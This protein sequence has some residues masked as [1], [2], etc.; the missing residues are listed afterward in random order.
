MDIIRKTGVLVYRNIKS[1]FK[2]KCAALSALPTLE[3]HLDASGWPRQY[4]RHTTVVASAAA[5]SKQQPSH[6][7][8]QKPASGLPMTHCAPAKQPGDTS[9][10]HTHTQNPIPV[11]DQL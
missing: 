5:G 3:Q 2:K 10:S 4:F 1:N 9:H 11:S 7:P 6:C 8:I